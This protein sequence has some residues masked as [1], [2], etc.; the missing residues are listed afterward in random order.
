MRGIKGGANRDVSEENLISDL[1]LF[2]FC[3]SQ[4]GT[5]NGQHSWGIVQ[6]CTGL[7]TAGCWLSRRLHQL[8]ASTAIDLGTTIFIFSA[9]D[10]ALRNVG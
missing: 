10:M 4:Q 8:K 3:E 6:G 9:F 5:A 7:W 2:S 1:G